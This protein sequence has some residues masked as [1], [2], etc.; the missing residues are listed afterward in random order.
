MLSLRLMKATPSAA[1]S[2]RALTKCFK[3]LAKSVDL[4]DQNRVKLPAAC[5]RHQPIQRWPRFLAAGYSLIGE[6][7][8]DLPTAAPCIF[9]QFG[10]LHFWIL[11][12]EGADS[13]VK[14][15]PERLRLGFLE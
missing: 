5:V 11:I 15:H 1:S 6:F 10:K 2:A 13:G 8:D 9:P 4:P 3:D 7:L 12:V 14:R